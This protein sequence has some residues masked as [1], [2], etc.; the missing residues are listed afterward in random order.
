MARLLNGA[1]E[2]QIDLPYYQLQD[3]KI[4]LTVPSGKLVDESIEMWLKGFNHYIERKLKNTL[5]EEHKQ[6][7]AYFYKS[8]L[9]NQQIKYTILLTES[10]NH[11][12]VIEELKEA[13]LIALHSSSTSET[14]IYVLDRA[15]MKTNFKDELYDLIGQEYIQYDKTIKEILNLLYQF[16]VYNKVGL[17]ASE[18]TPEVYRRIHGKQ[19]NPRTYESLGRTIRS[20]CNTLVNKGILLADAKKHYTLKTDYKPTQSLFE[21]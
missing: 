12:L 5:T 17:K 14:S 11:F 20:R 9:L 4:T 10:N 8:E 13:Q 1:L 3:N 7:L 19:I 18:L 2:N 16:T 6:V 21:L 15:L